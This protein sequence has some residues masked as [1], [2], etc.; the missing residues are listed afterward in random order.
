LQFHL[1]YL[2]F[3]NSILW[4]NVVA[5]ILLCIFEYKICI[6]K[7]NYIIVHMI[8]YILLRDNL[9]IWTICPFKGQLGFWVGTYN[10]NFCH[11]ILKFF[12]KIEQL[13][14]FVE[15]KFFFNW[16]LRTKV[17]FENKSY[18]QNWR[19]QV[20]KKNLKNLNSFF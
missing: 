4:D 1:N 17:M 13:I 7:T 18:A 6:L 19:D 12:W 15:N 11:A 3:P 9:I 2:N 10:L 5:Y 20:G 14:I 16:C 8:S